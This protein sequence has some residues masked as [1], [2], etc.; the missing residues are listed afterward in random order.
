MYHCTAVL[1]RAPKCSDDDDDGGGGGGGGDGGG[2][3]IRIDS[4]H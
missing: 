2:D 3:E 1:M 4:C